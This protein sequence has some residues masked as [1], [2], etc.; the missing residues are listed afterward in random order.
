MMVILV[1]GAAGVTF[2]LFVA[3]Y[4]TTQSLI[5]QY[6]KKYKELQTATPPPSQTKPVSDNA[7]RASYRARE[8][9]IL[10]QILQLMVKT[11]NRV[12]LIRKSSKEKSEGDKTVKLTVAA[13]GSHSNLLRWLLAVDRMN[14]WISVDGLSLKTPEAK[15]PG[16]TP[17][18][19]FPLRLSVDMGI[20][21]AIWDDQ[22]GKE[23]LQGKA[24]EGVGQK[25]EQLK[26]L[27]MAQVKAL[28]EA[29]PMVAQKPERP[30]KVAQAP[31]PSPNPEHPVSAPQKPPVRPP[32]VHK[33]PAT[34]PPT[35]Q[36]PPKHVTLTPPVYQPR[37]RYD[38]PPTYQAPPRR[39]PSLAPPSVPRW[40]ASR[41]T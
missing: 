26:Q 25:S 10:E 18:P 22:V 2:G 24:L 7:S 34:P 6:R 41:K 3:P 16:D 9:H 40:T 13:E 29:P 21:L 36:R 32:V 27:F 33:Q 14:D 19:R 15:E 31:P 11:D 1:G 39:P 23:L 28:G 4:L 20:N 17:D 30:T 8:G 37:P 12:G 35:A 38:A 5:A